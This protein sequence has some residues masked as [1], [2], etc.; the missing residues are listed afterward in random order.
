LIF[1]A[2]SE[3]A[4]PTKTNDDMT[5]ITDDETRK[6]EIAAAAQVD[7]AE[8]VEASA[9]PE[10]P[11]R[12]RAAKAAADETVQSDDVLSWSGPTALLRAAFQRVGKAAGRN[13]SLP[14][15]RCV[16]LRWDEFGL[17]MHA[18]S[19]D[20]HAE[21]KVAEDDGVDLAG[22]GGVAV[23]AAA[24]GKLL[25]RAGETIRIKT[26]GGGVMLWIG[27]DNWFA[28]LCVLSIEDMPPMPKVSGQGV[29]L[30]SRAMKKMLKAVYGA[31]SADSTRY[32][33][34]GVCFELRKNDGLGGDDV[35]PIRL[36]ATDG[37]RLATIA[38]TV[39]SLGGSWAVAGGDLMERWQSDEGAKVIAPNA[40]V[41]FLLATLSGNEKAAAGFGLVTVPEPSAK[42]R[43]IIAMWFCEEGF[44]VWGKVVDGEYP[45]WQKVLPR[46]S[47]EDVV[48]DVEKLVEAVGRAEVLAGGKNNSVQLQ[49]EGRI[50]WITGNE[51]DRGMWRESVRMISEQ[52]KVEKVCRVALNPD[53]VPI[54]SGTGQG[55][56]D[57]GHA[58]T[59]GPLVWKSSLPVT[60]ACD[61]TFQ[62]VL[63]PMRVEGGAA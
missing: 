56:L 34:N 60:E 10:K 35:W 3:P 54:L 49:L 58:R 46:P 29:F 36:V 6:A 19:L 31:T 22:K 16:G 48:L 2:Q 55:T 7:A 8:P 44:R 11:K 37:R 43:R 15:L 30:P 17:R 33:L 1:R 21:Q 24:F 51:A 23:E 41:A 63:M 53:Y 57:I 38:T 59:N 4:K 52:T 25:D 47:G 39:Q 32:V 13:N 40:L 14:I 12:K 18:T 9:E 45:A 62:Y 20:V 27:S 26:I 61:A 42:G 28:E 50:V 5:E